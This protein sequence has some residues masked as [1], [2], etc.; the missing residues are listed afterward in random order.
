M[1]MNG[2]DTQVGLHRPEGP[3]HFGQGPVR[4]HRP[5]AA[6][7]VRLQAGADDVYPVEP[8][9]GLDPFF[10]PG[11]GK[12]VVGR[13][14]VEVPADLPAAG[15]AAQPPVDGVAAPGPAAE[16]RPADALRVCSIS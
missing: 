8:G 10:V 1:D 2:T 4:L 7:G 3:L 15:V 11:P 6:E 12:A 13:R 16:D 5:G 14:D 9:L